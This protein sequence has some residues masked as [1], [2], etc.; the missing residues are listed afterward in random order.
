MLDMLDS[1]GGGCS[2]LGNNKNLLRWPEIS[3]AYFG[4]NSER[5]NNCGL[6]PVQHCNTSFTE[7]EIFQHLAC[8]PVSGCSCESPVQVS[9]A[10]RDC[11]ECVITPPSP[12]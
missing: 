12:F 2:I 6:I 8:G 3:S 7:P 9:L 4:F 10:K 1:M 5:G 11:Q